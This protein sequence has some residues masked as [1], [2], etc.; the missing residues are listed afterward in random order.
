MK[1]FE[2]ILKLLFVA[3]M[4]S[5]YGFR[6]FFWAQIGYFLVISALLGLSL[7]FNTKHQS[8]GYQLSRR[9]IILRRIEGGILVV[10][11]IVFTY[12]KIKGFI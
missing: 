7:I 8:Y 4:V 5:Y 9:E 10:F 1:Y 3:G 12:L 11:S 6:E 2:I